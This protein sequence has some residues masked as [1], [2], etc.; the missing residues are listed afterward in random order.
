MHSMRPSHAVHEAHMRIAV[1]LHLNA[2]I[3]LSQVVTAAASAVF[4]IF[5][6]EL[7][8]MKPVSLLQLRGCAVED[9]NVFGGLAIVMNRL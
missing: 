2:C 3:R 5:S 6:C 9:V 1:W 4:A 8:S 7:S